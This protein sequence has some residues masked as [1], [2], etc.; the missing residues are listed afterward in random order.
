MGPPH[1]HLLCTEDSGQQQNPLLIHYSTGPE[2]PGL[3][4][5]QLETTMFSLPS[6][7][8]MS[9]P[10]PPTAPAERGVAVVAVCEQDSSN[11]FLLI[12]CLCVRY[13]DSSLL[14]HIGS[15]PQESLIP[16]SIPLSAF[17]QGVGLTWDHRCSAKSAGQYCLRQEHRRVWVSPL[18]GQWVTC[19]LQTG[20]LGGGA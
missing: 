17:N 7:Q 8:R 20:F 6:P 4:P 1:G 15:T 9:L 16:S 14:L 3:L 2:R 13:F 18:M 19:V 11:Y 5:I 10:S 12:N